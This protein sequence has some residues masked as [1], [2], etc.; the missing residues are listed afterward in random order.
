MRLD[1]PVTTSAVPRIGWGVL[2]AGDIASVF[3]Q[4]LA[5]LNDEAELVAVGSRSQSKA[6]AFARSHGFARAHGSYAD[7]AADPGVDVVYVATVHNDHLNSARLCLEAGKAVLVEKPLTVSAAEAAELLDLAGARGLFAMEAVWTRT[8]PLIRRA[9]E[10][11]GGELG[12]VRHLAVSLGFRFTGEPT[13]RLLDPGQ[14]G[15]AIWDVGVYTVH[16]TQLFLGEPNSLWASG[17][18]GATGV[19]VHAAALLTYPER[20]GA[21]GATAALTCSIAVDLPN[22]LEVTCAEGAVL[23][24]EFFHPT[25]MTV[26]R[27]GGEPEVLVTQTPGHGFTFEAQEVMRCLRA[28]E[29]ESPL[30]PWADTRASMR[31]VDRWRAAVA[32]EAG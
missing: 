16:M 24:E 30:V 2:G 5:L 18:V 20:D 9:A 25:E 11:C 14:A 19:D 29:R 23:V 21:P 7:L 6:D 1:V 26:L 8:N 10:L 27:T 13:H 22:R 28:G 12:P 31:T 32:A 15:G 3:A 17:S 4:D